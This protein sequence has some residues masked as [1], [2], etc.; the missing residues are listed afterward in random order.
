VFYRLSTD[1]IGQK[2]ALEGTFS[3]PRP[4]PC[5]LI[6]GG[7]SLTSELAEEIVRTPVPR[8]CINLAGTGLL[9]P[10]LWTAYDPS[11]RFHRTVYLDPG[12]M[13]FVHR[14]RAMDLVPETTYKVCDCPQTYFFDREGRRG[15]G[16]FLSFQHQG[17]V[18]WADSMVQGIDI[19]YRLGFRRIYLA[20]CEMRVRPGVE[21]LRSAEA[22]GIDYHETELLSEFL[23]RC[24]KAGL[25]DET[26]ENAGEIPVYHFDEKKT[27]R[28]AANTDLHYFRVSQAMRLSRRSMAL[29]GLELISVTPG[30]R[31]N[32]YFRYAPI[33]Q[34]SLE[35]FNEIGD[36]ASENVSG[37]YRLTGP[38]M[39][40]G[41]GPMRDIKP[42]RWDE[43][44]DHPVGTKRAEERADR[45]S[46]SSVDQQRTVSRK[47]LVREELEII[48]ENELM[49][50]EEG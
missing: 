48:G 35:I 3:G 8:M 32:D 43:T 31:L 4:T 1:G 37:R 33:E 27:L 34:A 20:G 13:K 25:T 16:D 36:P 17:I 40:S 6:G 2:V 19:L 49:M 7:K 11:T 42:H 28:A 24:R 41:L 14:R 18:D 46:N 12:I 9:R 30:S 38:R 5:W 50:E 23:K 45:D 26:L 15:F 47:R 44:R 22:K 39:Q 21:H 10:N 29:A